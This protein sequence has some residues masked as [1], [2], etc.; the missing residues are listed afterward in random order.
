MRPAGGADVLVVGLSRIGPTGH[1]IFTAVAFV[2]PL[3]NTPPVE[4]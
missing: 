3:Q 2:P 1:L 4:K